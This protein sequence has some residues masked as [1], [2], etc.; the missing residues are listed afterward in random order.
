M[1]GLALAQ[2]ERMALGPPEAQWA[3]VALREPP[4]TAGSTAAGAHEIHFTIERQA[5]DGEA[6][7]SVEEK[8][9]FML[10]R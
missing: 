6:A 1:P 4:D 8:S 7:R 3:T 2:P 5:R 9:T 10:P